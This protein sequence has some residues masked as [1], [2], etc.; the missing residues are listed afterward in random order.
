MEYV[1][2]WFLL[3]CGDWNV[4]SVLRGYLNVPLCRGSYTGTADALRLEDCSTACLSQ[5]HSMIQSLTVTVRESY[6]V[7]SV[8]KSKQLEVSS[9]QTWRPFGRSIHPDLQRRGE[10]CMFRMGSI[11]CTHPVVSFFYNP[12]SAEHTCCWVDGLLQPNWATA[13]ALRQTLAA[14][15]PVATPVHASSKDQKMRST[16]WWVRCRRN[17]TRDL[18]TPCV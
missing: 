7:H 8:A 12:I 14:A 18:S 15:R 4:F 17:V 10:Y 1:I 3:D 16:H 5:T 9:G 2:L 11:P 13:I 6:H